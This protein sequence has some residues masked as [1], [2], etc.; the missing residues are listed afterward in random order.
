M[1]LERALWR[2]SHYW[3]LYS[4]LKSADKKEKTFLFTVLSLIDISSFLD[5]EPV[6]I[7]SGTADSSLVVNLKTRERL[8]VKHFNTIDTNITETRTF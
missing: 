5:T 7:L 1:E 2:K 4:S 3:V 6:D 8:E